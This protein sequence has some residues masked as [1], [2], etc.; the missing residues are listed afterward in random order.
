MESIANV[1][2]LI[3]IPL[4]ETRLFD[5]RSGKANPKM[6]IGRPMLKT[7]RKITSP[8]VQ[9]QLTPSQWPQ[10]PRFP[11]TED[12]GLNSVRKASPSSTVPQAAPRRKTDAQPLSTRLLAARL[13]MTP[14]PQ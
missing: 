13:N 3:C 6:Q 9:T 2:M 5:F 14:P 4:V 8:T 10:P 11:T 7:E 12:V 1:S